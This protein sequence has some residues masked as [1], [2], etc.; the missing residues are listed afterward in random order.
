ME[1][2]IENEKILGFSEKKFSIKRCHA[3]TSWQLDFY[4]KEVH[5]DWDFQ[6]F[7]FCNY[8]YASN[9]GDELIDVSALGPPHVFVM[10]KPMLQRTDHLLIDIPVQA[11]CCCLYCCFK[12]K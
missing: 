8:S 5:V 12:A 6:L 9:I 2:E 10:L 1:D 7:Q 3:A 4:N 11:V